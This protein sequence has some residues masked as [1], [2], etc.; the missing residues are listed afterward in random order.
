MRWA[1]Q[2]DAPVMR[3]ALHPGDLQ[4]TATAR[5]IDSMLE[6]WLSLRKQSFYQQL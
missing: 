5:S 3:I 4:Q 6:Q 1:L 2:R